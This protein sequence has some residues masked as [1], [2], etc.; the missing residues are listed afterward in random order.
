MESLY[1]AVN[2]ETTFE[3]YIIHYMN[4]IHKGGK[5]KSRRFG[6]VKNNMADILPA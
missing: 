5:S 6:A 2:I 1:C 3:S 4:L